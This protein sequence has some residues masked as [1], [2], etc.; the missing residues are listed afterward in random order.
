MESETVTV[1]AAAS[2][3]SDLVRKEAND[4]REM[5]FL[6]TL[7]GEIVDHWAPPEITGVSEDNVYSAECALGTRYAMDL[8]GH[9]KTYSSVFDEGG[10]L[11]HVAAAIVKRGKWTGF[12]IGFFHAL[13]DHIAEGRI[14]VTSDFDAAP[15]ENREATKE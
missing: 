9:I 14:K 12:E 15:L 1:A 4:W 6:K 8:I 11:A 5:P 10:A 7:R 13:G 2:S 3:A